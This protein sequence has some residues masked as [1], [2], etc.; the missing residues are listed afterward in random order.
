VPLV[1]PEGY[2][3]GTL[4]VID[5]RVKKLDEFQINSLEK[6]AN[7]AMKLLEFKRINYRLT[8]SHNVLSARYRDLEQFSRAVSHDIKSPLNNIMLLTKMVREEHAGQLDAEGKQ[9]IEYIG[10]SAEQLKSLVDGILEYYK[11]D[12]MD[13]TER[14]KIRLRDLTQYIIG[15]LNVKP[16]IQFILPDKKANFRSN[17]MAF[18]QILYNLIV[19][20]IKYNDKAKGVIEIGLECTDDEA[21][22]S[23]KDNGMGIPESQ[24]GKIFDIFTTL[25]KTD[26]FNQKGTGIGLSTVQK[27]TNKIDGRITLESVSGV[28]TT[29]RIHLKK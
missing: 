26:R 21:I 10:E 8:E 18:G 15:L 7:Q 2:P 29:F 16:D 23:V 12:T 28:G 14:E 1:T 20:A 4:C 3:L 11:F 25:G 24:F 13:V 9:M 6:L 17:K 19:N 22:I 5:N 27:L